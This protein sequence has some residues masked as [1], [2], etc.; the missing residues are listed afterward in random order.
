MIYHFLLKGKRD[1]ATTIFPWPNF[2][3]IRNGLFFMQ[4]NLLIAQLQN[5]VK[6]TL[7]WDL[8]HFCRSICDELRARHESLRLK[9]WVHHHVSRSVLLLGHICNKRKSFIKSSRNRRRVYWYNIASAADYDQLL[10]GLQTGSA[11]VFWQGYRSAWLESDIGL[12]DCAGF[13]QIAFPRALR[14][15]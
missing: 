10:Y 5:N 14:M 4:R 8:V 9:K 1:Y 11:G 6:I 7:N 2:K 3:V 15:S 13:T 12:D